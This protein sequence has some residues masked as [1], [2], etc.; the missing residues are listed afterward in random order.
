MWA[1]D[2][3]TAP[4]RVTSKVPSITAFMS[5]GRS[6]FSPPLRAMTMTAVSEKAVA[7]LITPEV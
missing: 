5:E 6:A 2:S 7:E 4:V 3:C 1:T